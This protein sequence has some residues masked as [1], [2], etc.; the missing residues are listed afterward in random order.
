MENKILTG[1]EN[2]NRI[3]EYHKQK[4][5]LIKLSS[6]TKGI[7]T[8][9]PVFIQEINQRGFVTS[10]KISGRELQRSNVIEIAKTD[11][12]VLWKKEK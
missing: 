5:V 4:P 1:K 2:R 6:N 3:L 11:G 12:T 9:K 10:L 7:D 8:D